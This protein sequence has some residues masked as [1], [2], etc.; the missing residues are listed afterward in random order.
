MLRK[1]VIVEKYHHRSMMK[2]RGGFSTLH[3]V[4]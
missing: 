2:M 4:P 1:T 3:T